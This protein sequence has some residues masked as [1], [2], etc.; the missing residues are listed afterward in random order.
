MADA[1][2]KGCDSIV[3][4]GGIQSN[5]ARATAVAAAQLGLKPHLVLRMTEP[6]PVSSAVCTVLYVYSWSQSNL[7]VVVT[8]WQPSPYYRY[9]VEAPRGK[10]S[11]SI[12]IIYI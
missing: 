5:H 10:I 9:L 12:A 4:C 2:G 8:A 7:C 3:T 6:P 11:Y 1:L